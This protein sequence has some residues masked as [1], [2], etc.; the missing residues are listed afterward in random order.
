MTLLEQLEEFNLPAE[1]VWVKDFL[2][3]ADSPLWDR[4]YV[5]FF[6]RWD[7]DKCDPDTLSIEWKDFHPLCP[8]FEIELDTRE[9]KWHSCDLDSKPDDVTQSE[10]VEFHASNIV[11]WNFVKTR[12]EY[13]NHQRIIADES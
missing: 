4:A 5:Y 10:M 6:S 12:L 9:L 3:T 7:P 11:F 8:S 2:S 13:C 1:Y